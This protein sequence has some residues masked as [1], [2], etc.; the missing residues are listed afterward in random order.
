MG[1]RKELQPIE[2]SNGNVSLTQ[3]SFFMKPEQKRLF[4]SILKNVKLPKRCASNISDRVHMKEMKI[5]GYKSHDA[6]FIMHYLLQVSVIKVLPKKVSLT[7]I[8]LS[9]FFW[10]IYSK[11]IR[12]R[13]LEKLESEITEIT[14]DLEIIFHP[15]FFYIM[16]H[17]PIHLVNEI[18][19]GGP[20]HL[21]W[22]YFIERDLR[23][24]KGLV[25]NRSCPEASI[26]EGY[27]AEECLKFCSRYLHDGEKTRFSRY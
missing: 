25:R 16:T 12:W 23:K 11:V 7:L 10:A 20:T 2:D 8:R 4:C 5:S 27:L 18:K 24:F 22:M 21:R 9:N 15:P 1:I 6:H 19:L 14:C 3:S 13:D 17:L 26:V